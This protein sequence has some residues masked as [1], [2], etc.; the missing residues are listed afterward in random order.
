MCILF[1]QLFEIILLYVAVQVYVSFFAISSNTSFLGYTVMNALPVLKRQPVSTTKYT[2]LYLPPAIQNTHW[3]LHRTVTD[4]DPSFT[5]RIKQRTVLEVNT[6]KQTNIHTHTHTQ[7]H[8]KNWLMCYPFLILVQTL[9]NTRIRVKI[10]E[11][12]NCSSINLICHV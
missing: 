5:H 1:I 2:K 10:M 6:D 7:K 4:M 12:M 11:S 8:A 9:V 3:T